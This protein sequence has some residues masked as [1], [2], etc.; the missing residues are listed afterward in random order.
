MSA[1]I[2]INSGTPGVSNDN[3]PLD[4]VVTLTSVDT[5]LHSYTWAIV[6]QPEGPNDVI[7]GSGK[8]VSFTPTKEGSYL[9]KLTVDFG[10]PSEDSQQLIA[11]V[12]ELETGDRIPAIGETTE[13]SVND[14]WA[15]PVDAVLQRVTRFTDAGVLPG[16]AAESLAVGDVVYASDTYTL[17]AGL[18][19]ERVVANWSKAHADVPAEVQGV[20]GVV[21]GS[22]LGGSIGADDVITVQTT[23]LYQGVPFASAPS[24]GDPVF[25]SDAAQLSLTQGTI[26]RQIGTV[27]DV[28]VSTYAVM[29]GPAPAE[30]APENLYAKTY[31][32]STDGSDVVGDGSINNPFATPQ[33]A[34][35]VALVDYPTDWV[36]VEIGPGSFVGALTIEKWNIVFH[37]AGSRPE[38]QATKLLGVVTVT[39]DAA[40]QKFNDVVGLDRLYVEPPSAGGGPALYVTGTGAFSVIVTDCYLTTN[41]ASATST[42]FVDASDP[43]R[44]RVTLNDCIVTVQ[45]AGPD[46]VYLDRGDVRVSNLQALFG[47]SVPSGSA[48]KGFVA[49]NDAT[50]FADR[51]LLDMQTLGPAIEVTGGLAGTKLTLSN[52]AIT[53]SNASCSHAISATNSSAPQLAAFVWNCVFGIGNAASKIINGAGSVGTNFVMVGQVSSLYGTVGGLG[54]TV[55]R[56]DMSPGVLAYTNASYPAPSGLTPPT[57]SSSIPVSPGVGGGFSQFLAQDSSGASQSP[58]LR[59]VA[60]SNTGSGA[61]GDARIVGGESTTGEGAYISA[62]G[63]TPTVGGAVAIG[64]GLGPLGGAVSITAGQGD[65][66]DGGAASLTAGSGAVD[67]GV[68]TLV[69]GAG[70]AVGGPSSVQGGAGGTGNGGAAGVLGGNSSG[71]GNGGAAVV[72]AGTGATNGSVLVGTVRAEQV[73]VGRSGKD[74]K[75]F[76]RNVGVPTTYAPVAA[77]TIPVNGPTIFLNPASNVD[78]TAS[79]TLATSG[80]TVGT[81]VTLVNEDSTF[82]VDLTQDAGGT[83]YLKL[84]TGNI[85]LYKYDTITFIFDGTYWVEVGRN[86]QPGKSY[87][88]VAGTTIPVLCP[89]ILL[90]NTGA[91]DLGT[92]NAT[93]QTVGINAGTRV[94]FVQKGTGTTTFRRGG[95]TLL[96]LTNA[97][98]AV[99][100]Y[101]TLELVYDGANW[102][103]LALANNA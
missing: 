98:H 63:A 71:G 79:P 94:T 97:S 61:G 55:T 77:T 13:N 21:A 7:V 27:C 20:F 66:T 69:G 24:V 47:A 83:S 64:A 51:L 53:L 92:A 42:V 73:S 88:P 45:A 29:V 28:G 99:A 50:L 80:I 40:T 25:I 34:H 101:G 6:S 30:I 44:P 70:A 14:G 26:R 12:R 89:V 91:V 82:Y 5:A 103:E 52:S 84:S 59:L 85:Y 56:L 15:N 3:L 41:S 102:C 62:S 32:V 43:L 100:Q 18:P 22:V 58:G 36:S 72:D 54:S 46:L 35:D 2:Q 87:T 48:G 37:G 75:T 93:I 57:G 78:M 49:I 39:P 67:G 68:A 11:A 65:T 90:A 8:I 76:G 96:R 1:I 81:I 23:G 19:G 4:T 74:V 9:V 31:W 38:T 60:G 10:Y 86:V 33:K 16:V 17:A 95:S